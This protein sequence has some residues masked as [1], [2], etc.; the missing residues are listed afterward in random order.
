MKTKLEFDQTMIEDKDREVERLLSEKDM[1][2]QQ[3]TNFE[4]QD[5]N[6]KV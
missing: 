1:L 6:E 2:K 3:V 5:K 4:K